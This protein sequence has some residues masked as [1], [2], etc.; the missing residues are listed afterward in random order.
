[1]GVKIT[2]FFYTM[3]PYDC[4]A[5]CEAKSEE[6]FNAFTLTVAGAGNIRSLTLR[7]FS[8][9]DMSRIISKMA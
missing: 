8:V 6:D 9:E 1:M 5:V 4:V 3:G 7:A 2:H